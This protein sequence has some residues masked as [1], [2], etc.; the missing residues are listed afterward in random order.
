[1]SK[2]EKMTKE[3]Q[4]RLEDQAYHELCQ[5]IEYA[6]M[7]EDIEYLEMMVTAWKNRYKKILAD[8]SPTFK[9]R[10]DYLL[11]QFYSE[12][13]RSI[14]SQIKFKEEK[15]I[16][17]QRKALNQ[18]YSLIRDINDLPTLK[19]EIKK[20]ET[21]YPYDSFLRMYKVK[22]DVAKRDKNLQENA[23]NQDEAFR[24]LYY[25]VVNRNGTIEELKGYLQ[26]WE[27]KYRINDKF[28]IDDFL[29]H[30]SEIKRYISDDYLKSIAKVL[31][32][33]QER[34]HYFSQY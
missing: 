32:Q 29:R 24:D 30:Q 3:E 17:N 9:K 28:K 14:L 26:D 20:W 5:I 6:M 19:K 23:F 25:G 16:K 34:M 11:N 18:L 15:A 13:I 33:E 1:M 7:M 10:I 22:I 21:K 8:P 31:P 27:K 12:V 4:Q 2:E